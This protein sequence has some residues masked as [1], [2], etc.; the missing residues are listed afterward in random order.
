MWIS[1]SL[2]CLCLLLTAGCTGTADTGTSATPTA[3]LLPSTLPVSFNDT[4][5][6]YADVNGVSLAYREFGAGEPLLLITGFSEVM[7]DWNE[8]FVGIL[9]GQYHVYI[10]DHRAM[11]HS[12][13]TDA[14]YTLPQLSDDA[15][16][17]MDALGYESMHVYGVSMGSSVSQQLVIDHPETVRKLVLSSSTYSA[18]LN[19]TK[20]LYDTLVACAG[21]ASQPL[22]LQKEASANLAWNGSYDGLSGITKDVMLIV[23]TADEVTPDAV[24]VRMAGQIPG[25]WLV[26]F[27][28]IPHVGSSY[29]PEE[30]GTT[31][32][33]FLGMNETPA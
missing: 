28:G 27:K 24:S 19:E 9:A 5:I 13:D 31:V 18:R 32:L 15:A 11:G 14:P 1:C 3:T 16:G 23:G 30:Y 17:L 26:R 12:G 21:N 2:I 33:T 22:G 25:S 20:K 6:Q 29:A 4:P 8:T 7:E 10:Y